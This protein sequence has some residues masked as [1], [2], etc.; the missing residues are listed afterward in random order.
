MLNAI[1]VHAGRLLPEQV[2]RA[3]PATAVQTDNIPEDS[4]GRRVRARSRS[5]TARSG[6]SSL[7]AVLVGR[8]LLVPARTAPAS[9]STSGP[10]A[11]RR[12]R[13]S[14]AASTSSGWSSS[15]CCSRAAIAGLIWMPALSASRTPTAR[16][17][18]SGLGF[19]GIAVALL[20]R[21]HPLGIAFGAL[22]FAFL[23]SSPTSLTSCSRHLATTS[24]RSPRASSSSRSSSP[25]RSSAATRRRRAARGRRDQ[26]AQAHAEKE[27]HGM[28]RGRRPRP[29]RPAGAATRQRS[30]CGPALAGADRLGVG[31]S[32]IITG[33]DDARLLRHHARRRSRH[34]PDPDGRASAAC[35]PSGPA[36]STSASR[37]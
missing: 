26:A 14:P 10:P 16:R 29:Q 8:R 28:S 1:A 37:A 31:R 27:V 35:G 17:S 22:L 34:L 5:A 7:L 4:S 36:W 32:G 30:I 25:T 9:A 13:P 15:R 18:R 11:C 21:N 20:G 2:R 33:A 19:T 12:P 24:S 3:A 6:R 23:A